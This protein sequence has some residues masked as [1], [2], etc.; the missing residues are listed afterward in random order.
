MANASTRPAWITAG[1]F[2]A[3]GLCAVAVGLPREMP[4]LVP[5]VLLVLGAAMVLRFRAVGLLVGGIAALL[6]LGQHA[7]DVAG[8]SGQPVSLGVIVLTASSLVAAIA[9]V[10]GLGPLLGTSGGC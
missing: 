5:G 7:P 9:A 2:A 8:S 4:T 6:L 3:T 1:L 10:V